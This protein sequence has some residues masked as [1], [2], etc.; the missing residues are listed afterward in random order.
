MAEGPKAIA[1]TLA[2]TWSEMEAMGRIEKGEVICH[3]VNGSLCL[4]FLV[5]YDAEVLFNS[6]FI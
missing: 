6:A 3:V 4:N 2:S 1:K 5:I